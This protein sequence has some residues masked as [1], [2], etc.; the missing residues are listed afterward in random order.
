VAF[1]LISVVVPAH[2]QGFKVAAS[3]A[4]PTLVFSN[5][6]CMTTPPDETNRL[7]IVEKHGRV[8][9]ITNLA[10]PT[11]TIFLD[12]VNRV[13]V[14][15]YNEASDLG[16]E[17][18]LLGLAFHPGYATNGYFYVTYTAT[19]GTARDDILSRFQVSPGNSNAADP[20]SEIR[21]IVQF[22][23]APNHNAGDMHFGS[24]G[25][26][27]VALGDEGG[28]Y[29][30]YGN[31]QRIDRDYFSAIIRIDVD[32]LPGNLP[33]NP[34]AALPSLTNYS[35]PVDNPWV[36]ATNFNGV[37]VNSNQVRTEFYCIGMRNP[38]RWSFD[39]PS[40]LLYVGHVGQSTFEWIN[41]IAKGDN[42]GWNYFEGTKQWTNS[43]PPGFTHV[44]PLTQYG[45]T[46][47]RTAIIGGVVYHGERVPQ[48]KGA[49]IYGDEGSSEIFMLRNTG[50]TVTQNAVLF[51]DASA[52]PSAFGF[53]PSNGDVLY[54]AL[55]SGNNSLI[56]R[57]VST[58]PSINSVALSDTNLIAGGAGGKFGGTYT[59]LSASD[60]TLPSSSWTPLATNTFD[61][62]GNFY[63]TNPIS[64][65][66]TQIF[67][68][69]LIP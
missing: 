22:D 17:E 4:F 45:H 65:D 10:A 60:L 44:P 33:P 30:Q 29:G 41:L 36:G 5:P 16:G 46:N 67:F 56:K 23:E 3:N 19:N 26:L 48:L 1:G 58:V 64:S 32:N 28:A 40:G 49:Y 14:G 53:D 7:F 51:P 2:A 69:V 59:L 39:P 50:M 25:Y 42:A 9:V 43:L 11:R 31:S 8:I 63:F 55:R 6:V 13:R 20:N 21:Y 54:L 52:H 27:Y 24:D 47:S 15:N 18:G 57:I 35:I 61:A 12:I 37:T 68:K 38:W 62:L 66:E 34:H